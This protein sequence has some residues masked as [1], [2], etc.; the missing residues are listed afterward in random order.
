LILLINLLLRRDW[1]SGYEDTTLVRVE[2][3]IA[4]TRSVNTIGS[5]S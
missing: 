3:G 1:R 4:S 2:P 5:G